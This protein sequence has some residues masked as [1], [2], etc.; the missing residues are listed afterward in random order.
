VSPG[1]YTVSVSIAGR[2]EPLRGS[3]TIEGDPLEKIST[4]DRQARQA[5]LQRIFDLQR[6][7]GVARVAVRTLVAQADSIRKDV[8]AGGAAASALADTIA[9]T[10]ADTRSELDRLILLTGT[11][12]RSIESFN[13]V[14]TAGQR[15]Q[16]A[17]AREDA[18]RAV[19]TLNRISQTD[20]PALYSRYAPGARPRTVPRLAA[21][22]AEPAR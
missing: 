13:T 15:Q 12:L 20:I 7:L 17:W 21:L 3:F 9:V 16:T 5:S 14:P 8:S 22:P 10:V 1:R 4:A 18:A 2:A 19:A 6:A 11:M